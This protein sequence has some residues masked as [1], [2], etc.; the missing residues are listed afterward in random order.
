MNKSYI[1]AVTDSPEDNRD[2]QCKEYLHSNQGYPAVLDLRPDLQPVRDQGRWGTCSAM[3]AATIK[4]WQEK[5][6]EFHNLD[7]YISP[8][9]IYNFRTNSPREGMFPRDT[10]RILLKQGSIKENSFPYVQENL[11]VVPSKKLMKEGAEMRIKSYARVDKSVDEMKKALYVN[12]PLYISM[13]VRSFNRYDY[14]FW[15]P[16]VDGTDVNYGGHAIS[17]VG[18]N[19]RGFIIQNSWG[20]NWGFG[21]Y[22]T[23]PYSEI[24]YIREVWTTVDEDSKNFKANPPM[25][26][27]FFRRV[28]MFVSEYYKEIITWMAIIALITIS[29]LWVIFT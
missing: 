25:V 6:D 16:L 21:G 29:S 7:E 11:D 5:H 2:Y 27:I 17:V 10:M 15:L 22:V 3:T 24:D 9:Y 28:S 19:D 26:D 20:K 1:C 14:K 23:L 4:E 12:G 18:Y 8:L 13:S